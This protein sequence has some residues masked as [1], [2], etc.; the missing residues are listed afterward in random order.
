MDIRNDR[1]AANAL[2]SSNIRSERSKHKFILKMASF[3][4]VPANAVPAIKILVY[5]LFE[6]AHDPRRRSISFSG[7][8]NVVM[9]SN[10]LARSAMVET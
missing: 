4:C 1:G 7:I 8:K 9:G 10:P 6:E 3:M 2:L 5:S